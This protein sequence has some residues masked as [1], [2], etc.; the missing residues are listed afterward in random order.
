MQ[1]LVDT[2]VWLR[3]FDRTDSEHANI[4]TALQSLRSGGHSLAT[5]PQNIA[6]FWNVSTRPKTARGG[7]GKSVDVTERRVEFIERF[8]TVLV[9]APAAYH[10]WRTLLTQYQIQGTA[11]HDARLVALMHT[12]GIQNI[13]TL[14]VGDFTRYQGISVSQPSDIAAPTQP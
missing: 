3:L 7:Y 1:Y 12:V 5:C 2:G 9:D 11:V 13:V 14:N 10:Q 4:R 6:E 8:A